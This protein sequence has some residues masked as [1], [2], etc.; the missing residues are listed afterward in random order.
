MLRFLF[1]ALTLLVAVA[2]QFIFEQNARG[3]PL[4]PSLLQALPWLG[5]WR[6]GALV[7]LAF[8]AA[9]TAGLAFGL[10]APAWPLW[11]RSE[12]AAA[13][14]P[15]AGRAL[16]QGLAALA[17][18]MAAAVALLL[19]LGWP[20]A[21]WMHWVWLGGVALLLAGAAWATLPSQRPREPLSGQGWLLLLVALLA[22][23]ALLAGWGGAE[24]PVTVARTTARSG[25][26]AATLLTDPA[27]PFFAPSRVGAP[28]VAHAP[29]ALLLW[30]RGDGPAAVHLLANGA[31]LLL[32]GGVWL[33]GSELLRRPEASP[34]ALALLAAGLTAVAI[35][36][37]HFGRTA[38]GLLAVSF[39]VLAGWLLLRGLRRENRLAVVASGL[40]TGAAVLL[41]RTG[42]VAPLLLALWWLGLALLRPASAPA[43]RWGFFGWW[44]AGLLVIGGPA[45]G[46]WLRDPAALVTYARGQLLAA[47][48][49]PAWPLVDLWANL[50]NN[51]L[52]LIWLSDAGATVS[53]PNHFLPALAA[54]LVWL[55]AGALL[56]NLDR[57]A[58]WALAAWL[59]AG[60]LF[61]SGAAPVAPDWAVLTPLLPGLALALAFAGDRFYAAWRS[62]EYGWPA[63]TAAYLLTGLLVALGLNAA[64]VY[65][66]FAAAN[67]DAVSAVGWA[68][69]AAAPQPAALVT[70]PGVATPALDDEIVQFLA[71]QAA[72]LL[73]T[74]AELPPALPPG[75]HLLLM[76]G[77]Q[78]ALTAVR[79]QH[80]G[81]ALT[82]VRDLRANPQLLVYRLP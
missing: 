29:L 3:E 64:V 44:L 16:S 61:A 66:N 15:A 30:L 79:T 14:P 22:V 75:S 65:Y 24:L 19:A 46:V 18:G 12:P 40:L 37:L 10:A 56:V 55:A 23:T 57:F 7:Q 45:A 80:P 41:D 39:T 70:S 27:A 8:W 74:V 59:L 34:G 63:S 72:P 4:P 47:D 58:G 68:V 17:C 9:L 51:F 26:A 31:A 35:P 49:A 28:G 32:V 43:R 38:P 13:Y 54:P 5:A 21:A 6:A 50:R 1:L 77:D 36:L 20:E 67:R 25:L 71:G 48:L 76:P 52:G 82:V 53:F 33:L 42:L 2:A 60:L 73:F 78:A 69:R 11:P 62:P 81:G